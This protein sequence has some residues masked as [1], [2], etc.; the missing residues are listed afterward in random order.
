[1]RG[2]HRLGRIT[3]HVTDR[4]RRGL[5]T[6]H[7]QRTAEGLVPLENEN[8][9][10]RQMLMP[11]YQDYVANV[12]WADHA[13][14]LRTAALLH[15]LCEERAPRALLDT[16]SG[17]SSYVLWDYAQRTGAQVVSVD[18][19]PTWMAKTQKFLTD[20]G[21]ADVG[22]LVLW[23]DFSREDPG[24]FDLIFHDMGVYELRISSMEWVSQ[25]VSANGCIVYDDLQDAGV[26]R[27]AKRVTAARDRRLASLVQVTND[28]I[29][30][31]AA[32]SLA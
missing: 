19:D 17:Y 31:Y 25:L 6:V 5:E 3:N 27:E 24:P 8:F 28:E 4:T 11:T 21:L 7:A 12:S 18:D 9:R 10:H 15:Q 30:R 13:V 16:G 23:Q 14:S 26:R 2:M 22:R 32:I 20:R 1:M 29:G